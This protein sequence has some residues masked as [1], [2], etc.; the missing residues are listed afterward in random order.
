MRKDFEAQSGQK[1]TFLP[2]ILQAV[3]QVQE[4][5]IAAAPKI[6]LVFLVILVGGGL[7]MSMLTDYLRE[8]VQVAFNEIPRYGGRVLPPR[9]SDPGKERA[10]KFFQ[11]QLE[12]DGTAIGILSKQPTPGAD[13]KQDSGPTLFKPQAQPGGA[14]GPA[15][16][17]SLNGNR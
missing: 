4:Q 1:L 11:A 2:F 6:L 8:S 15:E 16:Q 17:L 13:D 14:L 5:T 9:D 10:R 12:G 3:T 7:M